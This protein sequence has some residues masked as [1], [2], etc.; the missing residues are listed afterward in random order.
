LTGWLSRRL[1]PVGRELLLAGPILFAER[2]LMLELP[3]Q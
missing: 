3:G 2:L 1:A